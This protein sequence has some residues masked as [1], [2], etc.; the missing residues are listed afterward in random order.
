MRPLEEKT[1]VRPD[2]PLAGSLLVLA[3]SFLFAIMAA[4]V[5]RVSAEMPTV[6][7]VFFRNAIALVILLPMLL[8]RYGTSIVR[9]RRLHLH[10]VRVAAGL[11]AMYCIFFALGRMPLA[12]VVLLSFSAPLFIPLIAYWWLGEPVSGRTRLAV[13]VGFFGVVLILKPGLN[14]FRPVALVGLGAGLLMALAMVSIRRMSTSEPAVRI[15][16]YFAL[17]STLISG[18]PALRAW[19]PAPATL[20]LMLTAMGVLAVG[21]QLLLTAGYGLAPAARISA[22]GYGNVLFSTLIGWLFWGETLDMLSWAGA[23]FICLAGILAGY[24]RTA[25]PPAPGTV[26]QER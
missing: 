16:F 13:G 22:F 25:I 8:A 26:H 19:Q 23:L 5:K 15:V 14:M 12:E 7:V 6:M 11:G 4:I 20:V 1:G 18:I 2:R 24:Q 21:G 3:S 10:L 17:F 9:T